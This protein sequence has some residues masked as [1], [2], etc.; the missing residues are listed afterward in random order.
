MGP[1]DQD[2]L[3]PSEKSLGLSAQPPTPQASGG[4][5]GTA[6]ASVVP[7]D[8][9]PSRPLFRNLNHREGH[10]MASIAGHRK[11]S[12]LARI[13]ATQQSVAHPH[14]RDGAAS[15]T[16]H[17]IGQGWLASHHTLARVSSLCNPPAKRLATNDSNYRRAW[18]LRALAA[19]KYLSCALISAPF[20][21][22]TSECVS[23]LWAQRARFREL[24]GARLDPTTLARGAAISED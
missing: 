12:L 7:S 4:L 24:G 14:H 1:L 11:S 9:I 3:R 2:S 20:S 15:A 6:Q 10:S 18:A 17:P 19:P 16:P 21:P 23:S 8:A 13:F 5:L 22:H